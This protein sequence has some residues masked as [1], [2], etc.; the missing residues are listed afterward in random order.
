MTVTKYEAK[1]TALAKFAPALV[2]NKEKKCHLFC[3]G[4]HP[5]IRAVVVQF[6]HVVFSKLVETATVVEQDQLEGQARREALG[7]RK[8]MASK[9]YQGPASKRSSSSEA[10]MSTSTNGS[11]GR[12]RCLTCGNLH[13]GVCRAGDRTCFNSGEVGHLYKVCP[14][15]MTARGEESVP[16]SI[17]STSGG[18]GG[19]ASV[20]GRGHNTATRSGERGAQPRVYALTRQ[21]AQ[22][23]PDVIAGTLTLN[24]SPAVALFASGASHSFISEGIKQKMQLKTCPLD[25]VLHVV[26]P[27]GITIGVKLFVE[28][29]IKI[30]DQEFWAKLIVIPIIEFDVILGMNWLSDNQVIIDCR[31]KKIKVHIPESSDVVYYGYGRKILIVSA[32]QAHRLIRKGCKAYL[33]IALNVKS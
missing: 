29:K 17:A 10:S 15:R 25:E 28:V 9:T 1:F 16:A 3:T 30:K 27:F 2:P 32:I 13:G 24:D 20:S 19:T 33:A 14:R 11:Y 12:P 6:S 5:S 18:R 31:E 23:S 4:L 22:E 7:K 26:L 8:V 21:E